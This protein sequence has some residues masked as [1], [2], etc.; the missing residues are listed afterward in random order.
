MDCFLI[1]ALF[2]YKNCLTLVFLLAASLLFSEDP[3]NKHATVSVYAIQMKTGEVLFDHNSDKS[4]TPGS[5]MKIVTTGAALHL[6]G[7]ESRFETNLEYD[8][9]IDERGILHG[10]LYIR[11]GGDPSLGSDRLSSSLS[12]SDQIASWVRAIELCGI[13]SIEGGVFG[14]AT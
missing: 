10:N 11:G 6:L 5:C 2:N 7:Q 1:L 12:L 9:N 13:R 4:L 8:G 14:D 3:F